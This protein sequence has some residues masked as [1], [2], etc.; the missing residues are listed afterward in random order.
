MKSPLILALAAAATLAVTLIPAAAGDIQG[1]AYDC[2]ELWVMR[3]EIYKA[4]GYCFTSAKAIS[5]FGNAGCSYDSMTE[6]PLSRM[7]RQIIGDAKTSAAR[8]GC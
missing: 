5:Q 3:N 6:V 4:N 8:Q 2:N 1:D 7:D